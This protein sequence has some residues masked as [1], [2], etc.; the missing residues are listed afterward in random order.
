MGK[1]GDGIDSNGYLIIKGGTVI[2]AGRPYEEECGLDADLGIV[3]NGGTVIGV[4]ST[5]YGATDECEQPTMNLKFS[6]RI[7]KTSKLSVKDSSGKTIISYNPSSAGFIP[8]KE[9]REYLGAVISHPLFEL[10]KVYYLYLDNIQLYNI[11]DFVEDIKKDEIPEDLELN[12]EF[13]LTSTAT[14]FN[15]LY[16]NS[17]GNLDIPFEKDLPNGEYINT[18]FESYINFSSSYFLIFLIM[19]FYI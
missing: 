14:G 7:P 2:A 5:K 4:G 11:P 6:S 17:E 8:G 13:I 3:I 10:N 18:S 9:I 12:P 19:L 1:S 15:V 16:V